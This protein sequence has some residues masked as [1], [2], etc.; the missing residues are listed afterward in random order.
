MFFA[1]M[2]FKAFSSFVVLFVS[3]LIGGA[4]M[5]ESSR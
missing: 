3:S 4:D 5:K 2:S 1:L